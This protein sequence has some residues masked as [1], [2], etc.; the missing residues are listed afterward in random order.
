MSVD[1][2]F[3]LVIGPVTQTQIVRF[4]GAGGD[5]NPMH[6]DEEFARAAG[7]PGVFAMSQLSAALLGRLAAT[8]LGSANLRTLSVR[9]TAKVWPGDT[10]ILSGAVQQSVIVDDEPRVVCTLQVVRQGLGE[11]V[12]RGSVTALDPSS[13]A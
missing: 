1:G 4:A 12:A 5:F 3:E 2:E 6:H 10:L 13:T 11:V 7:Q 9:F 8:W